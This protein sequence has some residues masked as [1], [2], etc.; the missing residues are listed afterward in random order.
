[1]KQ[2]AR[3]RKT[4]KEKERAEIRRLEREIARLE[5]MQNQLECEEEKYIRMSK[6]FDNESG[7]LKIT[8]YL[9]LAAAGVV[10]FAV[11]ALKA[12]DDV[13]KKDQINHAIYEY[14]DSEE[15]K[16]IKS[17]RIEQYYQ[18]Y[19]EGKISTDQFTEKV[20]ELDSMTYV[21][22]NYQQNIKKLDEIEDEYSK[23]SYSALTCTAMASLAVSGLAAVG[24]TAYEQK[25]KKA[26][27]KFAESQTKQ[28]EISDKIEEKERQI[29]ECEGVELI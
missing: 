6:K 2:T 19:T 16:E 26:Y 23:K 7:Y 13:A 3:P 25:R 17:G 20:G 4:R 10:A 15:Y 27:H 5:E 1:M 12:G 18:Y 8:A 11:G 29:L 21:K 28:D 24:A 14:M 22:E 9:T